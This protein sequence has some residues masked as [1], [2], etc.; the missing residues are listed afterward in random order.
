MKSIL[1]VSERRI[2][3]HFK[4][5]YDAIVEVEE[6]RLTPYTVQSDIKAIVTMIQ[7]L[8]KE[9]SASADRKVVVYVDA[10][11][12]FPTV[13]IGLKSRLRDEKGIVGGTAVD[14]PCC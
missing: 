12:P 9:Q 14:E 7:K 10:P 4:E 11:E 13:L 3:A 8:S 2:T 6:D 1:I 5:E